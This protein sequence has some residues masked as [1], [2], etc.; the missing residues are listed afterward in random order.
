[1]GVLVTVGFGTLAGVVVSAPSANAEEAPSSKS[2]AKKAEAKKD[3]SKKVDLKGTDVKAADPKSPDNKRTGAKK[4]DGSGSDDSPTGQDPGHRSV[5]DEAPTPAPPVTATSFGYPF[6]F[7]E[8]FHGTFDWPAT[9]MLNLRDRGVTA[10]LAK[11]SGDASETGGGAETSRRR[12]RIAYGLTPAFALRGTVRLGIGFDS[13]DLAD[14][15]G[16]ATAKDAHGSGE[17]GS[18]LLTIHADAAAKVYGPYSFGLKYSASRLRTYSD[19][20]G[21]GGDVAHGND[22]FA[23]IRP[24]IAFLQ[25]Q[26]QIHLEFLQKMRCGVDDAA[27]QRPATT[28]IFY[29]RTL[30][31]GRLFLADFAYEMAGGLGDGLGNAPA[32]RVG[33]ATSEARWGDLGGHVGYRFKRYNDARAA[34]PDTIAAL[35]AGVVADLRPD[36]ATHYAL[37]IEGTLGDDRGKNDA[38][39][40]VKIKNQELTYQFS[41]VHLL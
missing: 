30:A 23:D 28:A 6:I 24:S 29:R 38:G 37:Q 19:R 11:S 7:S 10:Y 20:R 2:E 40:A 16:I 35:S 32:L 36:A 34:T 17:S 1:M 39:D 15:I 4:G 26:Y 31:P 25:A 3:E 13:E 5:R 9:G 21:T 12:D 18:Q 33:Y 22:T 14:K 27:L 41:F 8:R